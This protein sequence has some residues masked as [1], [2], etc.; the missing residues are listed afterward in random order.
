LNETWLLLISIIINIGFIW[1]FVYSSTVHEHELRELD[2]N[3]RSAQANQLRTIREFNEI[4][5][6]LRTSQATISRLRKTIDDTQNE[7]NSSLRLTDESAELIN[8]MSEILKNGS[9]DE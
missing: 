5:A 7:I 3:L 1:F 8:R 9:V 2:R 4:E 6:E